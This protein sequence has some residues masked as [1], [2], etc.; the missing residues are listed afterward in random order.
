MAEEKEKKE[1]IVEQAIEEKEEEVSPE[2]L[3]HNYVPK[4]EVMPAEEVEKLLKDL[5]V[6]RFHMPKILATDPVVRL[7]GAKVNEVLKITRKSYTSGTSVFYRVI[8]NA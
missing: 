1:K 8:V 7:M 5:K 2:V 4:F 6:D 3:T